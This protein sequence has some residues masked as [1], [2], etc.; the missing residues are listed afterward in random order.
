MKNLKKVISTL[1]ALAIVMSSFVAMSVSAASFKDVA[2]TE[3]Y[4]EAV[5]ALAAL[6]AIN[7]YEDGTFLPDNNITRAEAITMIVGALNMTADAQK[8]GSISDF[9][10][11][12]ANA[13]WAAGY[14]NVGVAQGFI[15]G[16]STTEFAPTKNVTYAEMLSMLTRLLGYGDYAN[17]KLAALRKTNPKA[18]WYEGFMDAAK[19]A[20]IQEGVASAAAADVT[21]AQVAQLI[22]NTLQTPMLDITTIAG[23][24]EDSLSQKMNGQNG[25]EWKTLLSDKFDA[26]VLD[27]EVTDTSKTGSGLEAGTIEMKLTATADWDPSEEDFVKYSV[28]PTKSPVAAGKTAAE[29]YIFSSAKVIAEYANDEWALLYFAPTAKI[30][31]K[32]VDGTLVGDVT[33]SVLK[34]KKSKISTSTTDYKLSAGVELYVNGVYYCDV[35]GNEAEVKELLADSVGDTVLYE[36]VNATGRAYNKIMIDVYTIA[37]VTQVTDKNDTVTVRLSGHV[38]PYGKIASDFGTSIEVTDDEIAD[39]EKVVTVTKAGEA[40]ELSALAKDDVIAI[41]H[42]IKGKFSDSTYLEILAAS[43]V[44]T[45]KYSQYDSDEDLYIID[46]TSYEA[47]KSL[48]LTRGNSY[49]FKMDPFGRLFAA[50][51]EDSAKLFAIVEKYV[52]VSEVVNASSEYDYLQVVTLDGQQKT[53]YVDDSTTTMNAVKTVMDGRSIGTSQ[54]TNAQVAMANR[55]IEY[56]VKSSNGR[57]NKVAWAATESFSNEEYNATTNKLYKALAST[58]VVLDAS[59]YEVAAPSSSD[60]KA[61]SL[62]ALSSETEYTGFLVYKNTN[63]Q[64]AYVVITTAGSVYGTTSN[65]AVAA[66]NASTASA[67]IVDDEEVYTLRVLKDGSDSA[68]LLQIAPDAVIYNGS[69]LIYADDCAVAIKK[70]A[71]FFYTVDNY[72]LVDRIDVVLDGGY[73]FADLQKATPSVT[74]RKPAAATLKAGEWWLDIDETNVSGDAPIQLFVAPVMIANDRAVTFATIVDD[75]VDYVDVEATY[76]FSLGADANIYFY[77]VSDSAPTNYTA[78]SGGAFAGFDYQDASVD[79]KAYLGDVADETNFDGYVQYAFVMV[80][81][82]TITNALVVGK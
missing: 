73:D 1:L 31:T 51:E 33:S 80:V 18:A 15:S 74:I 59:D 32:A 61:G 42:N 54:A 65:F 21:R 72:G 25:K 8:A 27:V 29:D 68:E 67:T 3:D 41:K 40:I 17:S 11:V 24:A 53:L 79:G 35:A 4:A 49:T 39:G 69:N 75:T 82:G 43:D 23:N 71:A 36:D 47:A 9:A 78:F 52:D 30:A 76:D 77:D 6:G 45:G 48:T 55:V 7:G 12:N 44:V 5:N 64:F 60:Y 26:Y 81:D 50:E 16:I 57:V 13:K 66:A 38:L 14:V 34:I 2:D 28:N 19:V 22:W 58:A 46:G 20:G 63:N 56:T 62:S 10:D 70:G 37:N